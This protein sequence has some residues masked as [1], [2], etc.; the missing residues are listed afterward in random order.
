MSKK[1]NT[2]KKVTKVTDKWNKRSIVKTMWK[3]FGLIVA[4]TL[5][6]PPRL[7]GRRGY[8]PEIEELENPIDSTLRK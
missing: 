3:L 7:N 4:V 5:S 2:A 6:F 1:R 8:L